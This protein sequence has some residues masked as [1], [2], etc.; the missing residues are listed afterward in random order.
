[1]CGFTNSY[2]LDLSP[3]VESATFWIDLFTAVLSILLTC[4]AS[5]TGT[6]SL[7]RPMCLFTSACGPCCLS[8]Y[9]CTVK[10]LVGRCQRL[11]NINFLCPAAGR[12]HT[13][14]STQEQQHIFLAGGM[15]HQPDTPDFTR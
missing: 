10:D 7:T 15:S 1:M 11:G 2:F 4:L 3:V 12:Q 5:L 13:S 9:F 8:V 6:I 14:H